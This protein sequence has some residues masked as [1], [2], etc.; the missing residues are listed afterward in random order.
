MTSEMARNDDA[1][2]EPLEATST[3]LRKTVVFCARLD[4]S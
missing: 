4:D 1:R 2:P 3:K